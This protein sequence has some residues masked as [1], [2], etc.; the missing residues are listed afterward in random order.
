MPLKPWLLVKYNYFEIILKLFQRFI[1][2]VTDR[3][4]SLV[5]NSPPTSLWTD[6]FINLWSEVVFVRRSLIKIY[7][8]AVAG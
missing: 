7:R 3:D 4:I 2:H 5:D 8:P 6:A 1:S